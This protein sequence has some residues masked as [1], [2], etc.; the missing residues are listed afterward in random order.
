MY[1]FEILSFEPLQGSK[2]VHF[3]VLAPII[4]T[5][6]VALPLFPMTKRF[7]TKRKTKRFYIMTKVMYALVIL[8]KCTFVIALVQS[9]NQKWLHTCDCQNC[10]LVIILS[11]NGSLFY[12]CTQLP[13]NKFSVLSVFVSNT[14]ISHCKPHLLFGGM[15]WRKLQLKYLSL[16]ASL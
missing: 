5:W 12:V 13:S 6:F 10:I 11:K 4:K 8:F 3:F 14:S 7:S 9:R 16:Y 1:I 15:N 2:V